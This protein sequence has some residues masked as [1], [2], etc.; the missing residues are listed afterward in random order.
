MNDLSLSLVDD[1]THPLNDVEQ[2][3]PHGPK[4]TCSEIGKAPFKTQQP[5][6]TQKPLSD[7]TVKVTD[8]DSE[9]TD[10]DS[11]VIDE[12]VEVT[13]ENVKVMSEKLCEECIRSIIDRIVTD[14]EQCNFIAKL[15]GCTINCVKNAA[16][17]CLGRLIMGLGRPI[18]AVMKSAVMKLEHTL[19]LQ[20]NFKS[21]SPKDNERMSETLR[22]QL[23]DEYDYDVR[24]TPGDGSCILWAVI[25]GALMDSDGKIS[26]TL[27]DYDEI[28]N[29]AIPVLR[30]SIADQLLA[31]VPEGED[32]ETVKR[33]RAI[34]LMRRSFALIPFG[35]ESGWFNLQ[36][37]ISILKLIAPRIKRPL[38]VVSCQSGSPIR[39]VFD[40][41]DS[42]FKNDSYLYIRSSKDEAWNVAKT[43]NP[44]IIICIDGHART[45]YA[46][47]KISDEGSS[48]EKAP[49]ISRSFKMPTATS[50]FGGSP[51]KTPV[52]LRSSET[53]TV[54]GQKP[55][56]VAEEDDDSGPDD[57]E[58]L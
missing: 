30:K 5:P 28:C 37:P 27:K 43:R 10:D 55:E 42:E 19:R 49:V 4:V 20:C 14:S 2:Q 53:S 57:F 36:L 50:Q 39:Q 21:V 31:T 54:Q 8:E 6:I 56:K 47:K 34:D 51:E 35:K 16:S 38:V 12:N 9:V 22:D 48:P 3:T 15:V 7:T 13:D 25:Q 26:L 46:Q 40:M 45:V 52:V 41:E 24:K 29:F 58:L 17:M 1:N 11:E 44:I 18:S 33:K 32:Q 23:G